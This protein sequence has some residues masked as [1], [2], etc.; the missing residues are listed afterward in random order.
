MKSAPFGARLKWQV[1]SALTIAGKD[2]RIYF[3]KP[4][5]LIFGLVFPIFLF[6][7][8]VIGRQIPPT[9]LLPGLIG[10]TLFFTASSSTPIIIPWETMN[11]TLERLASSPAS[12][13]AIIAG[14]IL[15]GFLYGF[16]ISLVPLVF[17]VFFFDSSLSSP[18]ILFGDMFLSALCFAALGSLF[19]T[20]PTPNPANIML[21]SNLFRLPLLFISGVFMPIDQLPAWGKAV[22]AFSPLTYTCDLA[23][24]ALLGKGYYSISQGFVILSAYGL[25]FMVLCIQIHKK[26]LP[27]R[28]S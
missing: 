20:L 24:H 3:L 15:A 6:G 21:I 13:T 8:F 9:L 26:S 23:R 4:P 2:A 25:L 5:V 28:L 19:S 17:G 16:S 1:R 14:D 27:R 22:A 7:A 10:M 18:L 11:R 12:V